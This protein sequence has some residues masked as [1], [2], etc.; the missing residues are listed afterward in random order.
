MRRSVPYLLT[1]Q[2]Q[3]AL[4]AAYALNSGTTTSASCW[5]C[6]LLPRTGHRRGIQPMGRPSSGRRVLLSCGRYP[7]GGLA[8]GASPEAGGG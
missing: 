5:T 6:S 1:Q 8:R 3:A 4:A 2:A 7:I